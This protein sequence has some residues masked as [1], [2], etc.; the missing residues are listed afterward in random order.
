MEPGRE[1]QG[2]GVKQLAGKWCPPSNPLLR[3]AL[4]TVRVLLLALKLAGMFS[5]A[6]TWCV[7]YQ[8]AQSKVSLFMTLPCL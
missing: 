3:T 1:I 5:S 6:E 4:G 7:N 8:H 2:D